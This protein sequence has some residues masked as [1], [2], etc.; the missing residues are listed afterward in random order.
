MDC[1]V[2]AILAA[3]PLGRELLSLHMAQHGVLILIAAPLIVLGRPGI[4]LIWSF[5]FG[6]I[7]RLRFAG[8]A[9]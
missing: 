5:Q 1:P 3:A 7:S 9:C 4:G 8:S 2:I 6:F